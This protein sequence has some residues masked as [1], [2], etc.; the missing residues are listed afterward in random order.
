LLGSEDVPGAEHH[1]VRPQAA[2]RLLVVG[3]APPPSPAG[4]RRDL[5][6]FASAPPAPRESA[7]SSSSRNRSFIANE[8]TPFARWAMNLHRSSV[9]RLR[10]LVPGPHAPRASSAA[11]RPTAL[12][13]KSAADRRHAQP[14]SLPARSRRERWRCS[15]CRCATW[16]TRTCISSGDPTVKRNRTATGLSEYSDPHPLSRAD[17]L[18]ADR[19][20]E[21]APRPFVPR[22]LRRGGAEVCAARNGDKDDGQLVFQSDDPQT[23]PRWSV[24]IALG[25]ARRIFKSAPSNDAG[26]DDVCDTPTT[27]PPEV[28]FRRGPRRP[29]NKRTK[30]RLKNQGHGAAHAA[31][32]SSTRRARWAREFPAQ[33]ETR[34]SRWTPASRWTSPSSSRPGAAGRASAPWRSTPAIRLR[35]SVQIPLRGHR[36]RAPALCADPSPP[37]VRAGHGLGTP[38]RQAADADVVWLGAGCNCRRW[39]STRSRPRRSPRPT[40]LRRRRC[41]PGRRFSFG[42]RFTPRGQLRPE[43]RLEDSQRRPARSVR[44][45]AR[46]RGLPARVPAR[47]GHAERQL[48]PGGG[49]ARARRRDVDRGEPR[50]GRLQSERGAQSPPERPGTRWWLPPNQHHRGCNPGRRVHRHGAVLARPEPTTILTDNGNA[51]VRLRRSGQH[52]A[53]QVQARGIAGRQTRCAR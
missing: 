28:E 30:V 20:K 18:G 39:R 24:P 13:A 52:P 49:K 8:P 9:R 14:D 48:R 1:L 31:S 47:G 35:P 45:A 53:V 15:R 7:G 11:S 21:H 51:G 22:R 37:R 36:R 41:S 33:R 3:I 40:C 43:R 16:A 46:H 10:R 5:A 38:H 12:N 29:G 50:A 19:A 17:C 4:A 2:G 32:S 27:T 25:R 23:P 6:W 42:I 26:G 34:P 44:A